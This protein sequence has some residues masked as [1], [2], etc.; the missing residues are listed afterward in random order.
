MEKQR[1]KK[2]LQ[3]T[4]VSNKMDKTVV[5]AIKRSSQ[6]PLYKKIQRTTKRY[7]AHDARNE[8]QVGDTVNIMECRPMSREK[9]FRVVQIVERAK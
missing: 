8:C 5:V 7:K 4:V 9:N 2:T 6:H 1:N 3:G